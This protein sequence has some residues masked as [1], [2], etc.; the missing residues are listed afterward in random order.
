MN[1]IADCGF[2]VV[3]AS[4]SHRVGGARIFTGHSAAPSFCFYGLGSIASGYIASDLEREGLIVIAGL[5]A[6][7]DLARVEVR[8]VLLDR[9]GFGGA[10]APGTAD[11]ILQRFRA[12]SA[13][14]ANKSAARLF[15]SDMSEGLVGL[16]LRDVRAALR[17]AGLRGL[18]RKARRM[19]L[20]HVKRL[21]RA[22]IP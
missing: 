8:P 6:R 18:A 5:T 9:S 15:Y 13:E 14:I 7:G 2:R 1:G 20:R 4:H 11:V 16:Y 22:V 19:R 10:P 3:A 12:L 17:Q 21:V